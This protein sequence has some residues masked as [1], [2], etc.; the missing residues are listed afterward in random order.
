MSGVEWF[1]MSNVSEDGGRWI[2]R[3]YINIADQTI[4]SYSMIF[5]YSWSKA[6]NRVTEQKQVEETE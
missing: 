6:G 1:T 5:S 2:F 4:N 3:S